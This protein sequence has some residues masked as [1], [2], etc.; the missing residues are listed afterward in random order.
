MDFPGGRRRQ[1]PKLW[2]FEGS[3]D[4]RTPPVFEG[5][6]GGSCT[7]PVGR[8]QLEVVNAVRKDLSFSPSSF[9]S[10]VSRVFCCPE[11]VFG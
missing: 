5:S 6:F 3:F 9:W 4:G 8:V 2:V 11:M 10:V 1:S 7:P